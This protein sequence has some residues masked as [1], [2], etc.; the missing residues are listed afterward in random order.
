MAVMQRMGE[1][2]QAQKKMSPQLVATKTP[3]EFA[4]TSGHWG[5]ALITQ[6][7]GYCGVASALNE[8]GDD[9][10]PNQPAQRNYA[11][12][13]IVRVLNCVNGGAKK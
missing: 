7:S 9:F 4:D 10:A 11:A 8:K 6:M 1:Y 12:A 2:L 3:L 13:A 5:Q